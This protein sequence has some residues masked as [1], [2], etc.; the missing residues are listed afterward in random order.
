MLMGRSLLVLEGDVDIQRHEKNQIMQLM[1]RC[2]NEYEY[3]DN[4]H[5]VDQRL[6]LLPKLCDSLLGDI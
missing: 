1:H 2:S 6:I 4:R 5:C 3:V